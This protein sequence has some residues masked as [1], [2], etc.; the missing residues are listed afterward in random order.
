MDVRWSPKSRHQSSTF[1]S[2]MADAGS[3]TNLAQ[4]EPVAQQEK[5]E[6]KDT[7]RQFN[8]SLVKVG[9]TFNL[10]L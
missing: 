9:G 5:Q 6:D 2:K 10:V 4:K 1:L 3:T 8:Y 7:R